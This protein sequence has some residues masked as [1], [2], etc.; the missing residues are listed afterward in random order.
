MTHCPRDS[1]S[2]SRLFY[3]R[4]LLQASGLPFVERALLQS[5]HQKA[6]SKGQLSVLPSP[7]PGPQLFF[8]PLVSRARP[9][10]PPTTAVAGPG[11]RCCKLSLFLLI[12]CLCKRCFLKSRLSEGGPVRKS[13]LHHLAQERHAAG[14]SQQQDVTSLVSCVTVQQSHTGSALNAKWP[15]PVM[16]AEPQGWCTGF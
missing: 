8:L 6:T 2:I 3:L 5:H 13:Q 11:H 12:F 10:T 7:S 15:G 14:T 16:A 1:A 4:H 9:L